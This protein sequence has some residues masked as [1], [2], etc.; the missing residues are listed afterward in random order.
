MW[1]LQTFHLCIYLNYRLSFI[2]GNEKFKFLEDLLKTREAQIKTKT[3]KKK[4]RK[5][6]NAK[7]DNSG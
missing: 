3:P 7:L 2:N 5:P 1:H 6:K 4:T